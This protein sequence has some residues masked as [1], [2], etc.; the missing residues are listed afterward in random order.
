MS[1][2]TI[3]ENRTNPLFIVVIRVSSEQRGCISTAFSS[4]ERASE[5]SGMGPAGDKES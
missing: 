5:S 1:I 4:R 3:I 2:A